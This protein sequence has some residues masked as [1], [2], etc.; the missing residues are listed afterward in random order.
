MNIN[1]DLPWPFIE[2]EANRRAHETLRNGVNSPEIEERV[3]ESVVGSFRAGTAK[4]ES[5]ATA[6]LEQGGI[7]KEIIDQDLADQRSKKKKERRRNDQPMKPWTK[8]DLFNVIIFALG[9]TLGLFFEVSAARQTSLRMDP[10]QENASL[11][12]LASVAVVILLPLILKAGCPDIRD[13]LPGNRRYRLILFVFSLVT[14]LSWT[15]SWSARANES[16][17]NSLATSLVSPL[18]EPAGSDFESRLFFVQMISQALGGAAMSS[19]LFLCLDSIA[20]TRCSRN[21]LTELIPV[22]T[23]DVDLAQAQQRHRDLVA[24]VARARA[25][26]KEIDERERAFASEWKMRVSSVLSAKAIL[27]SYLGPFSIGM[28]DGTD[29]DS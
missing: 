5:M 16:P 3:A 6:V 15:L 9:S 2:R 17:F 24:S 27:E 10:L 19:F 18:L 21:R 26:L 11:M 1:D 13:N 23:T 20:K 22:T 14:A 25:I 4:Y 28:D 7:E 29:L 8:M 12:L